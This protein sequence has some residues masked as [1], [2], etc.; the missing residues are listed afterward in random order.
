MCYCEFS[1][2]FCFLIPI[3]W[4]LNQRRRRRE[5]LRDEEEHAKM[6]AKGIIT[7]NISN[8]IRVKKDIYENF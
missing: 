3:I 1:D 7:R 4:N 5:N 8:L 6:K 2:F